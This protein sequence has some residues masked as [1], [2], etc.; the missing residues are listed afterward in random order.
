MEKSGQDSD[1]GTCAVTFLVIVVVIVPRSALAG[2]EA[3]SRPCHVVQTT[4]LSGRAALFGN[5]EVVTGA[6]PSPV[7]LVKWRF[8]L[9]DTSCR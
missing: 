7:F 8:S 1:W 6:F 9:S 2:L 4:C 3:S 5:Q